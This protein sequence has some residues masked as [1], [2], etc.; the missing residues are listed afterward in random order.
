MQPV[1]TAQQMHEIDQITIQQYGI[2]AI[3]L[4][5]HAALSVIQAMEQ[6]WGSL[7]N[8]R[9][10]VFC[11]HG[12]NGGDGFAIARLAAHL[13]ARVKVVFS[14]NLERMSEETNTNFQAARLHE[15]PILDCVDG[16]LED[17]IG[18]ADIIVDALLGTGTS[19]ILRE[20]TLHLVNLINQRP[21]SSKLVAVDIPTGLQADTG[22]ILVQAVRADL[23]VTFGHRKPA[24]CITPGITY[25]G[26]LIVAD[27]GIPAQAILQVKPDLFW[28]GKS[29]LQSLMPLRPV[30]GH[31]GIFGHTLIVG[32]SAGFAGAPMLAA[33][34]AVKAGVGLCTAAIPDSYITA[35]LAVEPGVM[36]HGMGLHSEHLGVESEVALRKLSGLVKSLAIGPG[37]GQHPETVKLLLHLLEG[38]LPPLVLDADALNILAAHSSLV[39]H[40]LSER[41]VVLTPHPGELARLMG[42]GIP[43]IQ[44]DRIAA[45]RAAAARYQSVVVLKG[46]HS[47]VAS[48][49][50]S[51]YIIATGN[52]ILAVGGSGDVLTGIIAALMAQGLPALE[53]AILGS[54]WHGLAGDVVAENLG[55]AGASPIDILR[56]I[57][58]ARLRCLPQEESA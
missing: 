9:T 31:K 10:L 48:A 40:Q 22:Q 50:G 39:S 27:I 4:M 36:W 45:A 35:G 44:Q 19:G 2:P 46:A 53:A 15:I 18:R 37:L 34:A 33:S 54:G 23:T 43:E 42:I 57:P 5:E 28:V 32:G 13:G 55:Q 58:L 30:D 29:A 8:K 7:H 14:G 21:Q 25:C 52:P 1:V 51:A 49:D 38:P 16:E 6:H 24:L 56:A 20:E 26:T 12:N 17:A 11:G 3:V 41:Q 47:V